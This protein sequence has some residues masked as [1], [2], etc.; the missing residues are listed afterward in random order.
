[1]NE[2]ISQPIYLK[3]FSPC[4][5][6]LSTTIS[7]LTGSYPKSSTVSDFS[8]DI[9]IPNVFAMFYNVNNPH[10]KLSSEAAITT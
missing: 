4:K 3:F 6:S 2:A 9:S 10:C 7:H 5:H 8:V 1:M